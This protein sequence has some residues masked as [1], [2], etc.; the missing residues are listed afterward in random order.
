MFNG[1]YGNDI[2]NGNLIIENQ[3][4]NSNTR[5]IRAASYYE[6]WRPDAPNTNYPALDH[7]PSTVEISDRL[8]E[9]G[10]FLRLSNITLSYRFNMK[11]VK[12]I[13]SCNIS[14]S[15]RNLFLLSNYSGWDPEVNSFT[16]NPLKVGIDWGS[17]PNYRAIILA[18]SITF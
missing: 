15:G 6:A 7:Y 2:L 18:L 17:Y 4:V 13:S 9:D 3:S 8:I 12:Q 5:N 1:V 16:N 11:K 14:V 10:S